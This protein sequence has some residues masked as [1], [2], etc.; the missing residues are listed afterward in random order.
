MQ[1]IKT[2]AGLV[3][4]VVFTIAG[5]DCY[6]QHKDNQKYVIDSVELKKI[7]ATSLK[8]STLY[9]TNPFTIFW[10]PIPYT[11]E[12]RILEEFRLNLNQTFTVGASYLG[13]SPF[14][15][16]SANAHRGNGQP[17][18]IVQGLRFQAAYKYYFEEGCFAPEGYY[19]GSMFSYSSAMLTYQQANVFQNYLKMH[20]LNVTFITGRQYFFG[21]V[22]FDM[23]I[24][25]GY[26]NNTYEE[27]Y[28]T[29][30]KYFD[31]RDFPL[32][33]THF[34]FVAGMNIG[35]GK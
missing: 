28:T 18:I 31:P 29:N 8:H 5:R 6:S 32:L 22:A 2:I 24:G 7:A 1:I 26:K 3:T 11:S 13:L 27:H 10:G 35:W 9:K 17:K 21:N 34:K 20:Y 4:V 19:M 23:F 30:Y 15:A 16:M 33:K 12:Y 25:M 14:I